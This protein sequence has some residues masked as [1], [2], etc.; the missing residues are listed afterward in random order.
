MESMTRVVWRM[1]L[2]QSVIVSVIFFLKY[3]FN[4]FFKL[5][6]ILTSYQDYI[7]IYKIN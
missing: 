7:L 6:Y 2:S 1:R 3:H 4:F 5:N